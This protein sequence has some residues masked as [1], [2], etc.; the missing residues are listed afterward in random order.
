L[1]DTEGQLMSLQELQNYTYYAKYAR[2]N[3]EARRRETWVEAV[4]R[5]KQMHLR[6]YP[7]AEAEI[8]W[9]FGLVEQQRVLGSQRALQFG[10]DP[11]ERVNARIYN[12]VS[13]HCDRL[14]F[15]QECF[16]LLLCG[17]GSGF[18]VQRH[19][20]AKL[21]AF[22]HTVAQRKGLEAKTFV[23]P[24]S[25]EG[26]AD[27]LGVLLSSYFL[28]PVFS[29]FAGCVVDFDP[30]LI[31]PE[32][33]PISSA[34]G[35]APGPKPLIRALEKI[36]KLLDRCLAA[37]Q[38][39]LRPIDAYDIVM[40]ASDA[41]LSGG[42]RRSATICVF[43]HDD[44][45]M[46]AAKTGNWFDENPQ[47]GRS[48]NSVLLIRD[49]TDRPN[50]S[51]IMQ[52]VREFG[53]PGFVFA[54]SEEFIVNP[55]LRAGTRVLTDRGMLPIEYLEGGQFKV[56]NL[57]GEW[58]NA[59]CRL[60]GENEELY[61]IS[62][63]SGQE[64]YCTA[65]HKWPVYNKRKSCYEKK[66]TD[67]LHAGDLLP[68]ALNNSLGDSGIGDEDDG[69]LV[70]WLY[71]DGWI[72]TRSD[73][74][75]VQYGMIVSEKDKEAGVL[76]RLDGILEKKTGSSATWTKRVSKVSGRVTYEVC[77]QRQS[78]HDYFI[79]LGVGN[80]TDGLPTIVWTGSEAFRKGFVDGMFSSD[81]CVRKS[82]GGHTEVVITSSR[83]AMRDDL[84]TLLGFYGIKCFCW[85]YKIDGSKSKFPNGKIY[86]KI[87][88]MFG[89]RVTEQTSVAHFANLFPLT[90]ASKNAAI[91][92][93]K[94]LLYGYSRK[95]KIKSVTKTDL[96]EKV[97]DISVDDNTHC[98]QI[99][100]C[101]TGNCV[102][103]G[104]YPVDEVTG[105]TGWQSCNLSTINGKLVK[106]RQDFLE[107]AT[108]ASIIGTLQAGYTS[109]PYLGE[110]TERIV[111]REALLG[112]SIT[113]MMDSPDILFNPEFQREAAGLVAFTNRQIADKIGINPAARCT[114]IKPEGTTS[115]MLGT[116][117]GIHP[118]HARRYFRR[119]QANKMEHCYQMFAQHNP[120]ACEDSVWSANKTDGVITFCVEIP[121]GGKNKAEIGPIDMLKYVRLTQQNWVAAGKEPRICT[122]PWLSHNVSNTISVG[123]NDWLAVADYIYDNRVDF[124]AV[125][126]LPDSGDKDY[127]QAPF[128]AVP[129]D[130]EMAALYSDKAV[131]EGDRLVCEADRAFGP[132]NLWDACRAALGQT[133]VEYGSDQAVWVC[134]VADFADRHFGGKVQPATYCL[135][136]IANRAK[137]DALTAAYRPVDYTQLVEDEDF[138][139][140]MDTVACSGGQCSIAF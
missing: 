51:E 121:E 16:W 26:W 58:V 75:K 53:E 2:H 40:H 52:K 32:G 133:P 114:A 125:S 116:A 29:E 69:F 124:T 134:E 37:G 122:Q 123:E 8:E 64:I 82:K 80:K 77:I 84:V 1:I 89:L 30:S 34:T 98:Y 106:S 9:A 31:R 67:C 15:F 11:I 38:D 18:S 73:N 57:H 137:W 5:M 95:T 136:D 131:A 112:V 119:V 128:E 117:S 127:P 22:S 93:F 92:G 81:G 97:W 91:H 63:Y 23:I 139:K 103:I 140:P 4:G 65:S 107:A 13:S 90:H 132:G 99:S 35:K 101:V 87:Y 36:R 47:R 70:G 85:N 42:V 33:S 21:P 83:Q 78:A 71:G 109:F 62:L 19:H 48:N 12:C 28:V 43:S 14:R 6:R 76:D 20:I 130:E 126:L 49:K 118:H 79:G 25:I 41:V 24:D 50:F 113:G 88:H 66:T 120:L 96:R 115:C 135:K 55:S 102:E 17:A 74:G 129:T 94:F 39:R 54:D 68:V 61:N 56:K 100:G 105:Q 46:L 10:G 72:T 7:Q 138:T 86:D 111:R 104:M 110:V 45:E 27:A 60:S 108:A 44:T 3:K 59:K